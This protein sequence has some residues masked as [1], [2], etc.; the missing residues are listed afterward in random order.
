MTPYDL[1]QY[2]SDGYADS[3]S[4]YR[5]VRSGGSVPSSSNN[6]STSPS[7]E[8]NNRNSNMVL[9]KFRDVSAATRFYEHFNG[10]TF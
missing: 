6:N 2:F 7:N 3:I 4:H 8:N 1:M 5:L 9:I 10:R